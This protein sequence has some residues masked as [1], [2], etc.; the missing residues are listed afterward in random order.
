MASNPSL[1]AS[2][3]EHTAQSPCPLSKRQELRKTVVKTG[4]ITHGERLRKGCLVSALNIIVLQQN[5]TNE[6]FTSSFSFLLSAW[7]IIPL[8]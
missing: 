3:A 4:Q 8:K 7:R 6:I 5:E 2:L 1:A